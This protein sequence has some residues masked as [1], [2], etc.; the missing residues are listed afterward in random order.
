[1]GYLECQMCYGNYRRKSFLKNDE[2][3]INWVINVTLL[4]QK[5]NGIYYRIVRDPELEN[6]QCVEKESS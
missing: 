1:M 2:S 5:I 4:M 6:L 3:F